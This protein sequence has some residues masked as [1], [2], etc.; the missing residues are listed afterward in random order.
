[1]PMQV[2]L[3]ATSSHRWVADQSYSSTLGGRLAVTGKPTD[4]DLISLSLACDDKSFADDWQ[5]EDMTYKDGVNCSLGA[6][7]DHQVSPDLFVRLLGS[8]ERETPSVEHLQYK[9]WQAGAGLGAR[10][11]SGFTAYAQASYARLSFDGL[12][13]G[14]AEARLDGRFDASLQLSNADWAA[15]GFVPSLEYTFTKNA[16]NVIFNEF[17]AHGLTFTLAREF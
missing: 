17:N 12:A 10:L 16:S 1:M 7:L 3:Y 9:M 2:G 4:S 8:G 6:T 14:S 15:F 11:F 5:S 13:P